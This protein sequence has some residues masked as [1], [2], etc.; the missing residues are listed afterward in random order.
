MTKTIDFELPFDDCPGCFSF[1]PCVR[2][3]DFRIDENMKMNCT[4]R[5]YCKG[6]TFCRRRIEEELK[7]AT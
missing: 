5:F 4:I 6:E 2:R 7:D 1:D 3:S